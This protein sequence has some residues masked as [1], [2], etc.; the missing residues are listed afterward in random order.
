MNIHRYDNI[1]LN[2]DKEVNEKIRVFFLLYD[3]DVEINKLSYFESIKLIN[4]YIKTL[5]RYEE[6]EAVVAFKQRKFKRQFKYRRD[7]RDFT[8]GLVYRFLKMKIKKTISK[9]S[10][11][12]FK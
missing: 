9:W 1:P 12:F 2:K 3:R 5:I 7:R 6:F 4:H 10:K 8:P 11:K